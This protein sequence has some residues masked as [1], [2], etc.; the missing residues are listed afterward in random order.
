MPRLTYSLTTI[1]LVA[2]DQVELTIGCRLTASSTAFATSSSG[3]TR[4]SRQL[5]AALEPVQRLHRPG[6]VDREEL[7]DVR[8]GERRR[9]HV[10]GGQL[11]HA[12]DRDPLL[13]GRRRRP[14]R[15][16]WPRS[17]LT[18]GAR[19]RC[20]SS[21]VIEP[22]GRCRRPSPGRRRGPGPACAPAAWPAPGP[23]GGRWRTAWHRDCRRCGAGATAAG[24]ALDA[25]VAAGAAAAGGVGVAY[26]AGAALGRVW[27]S[28][29]NRPA[30]PCG[31]PAPDHR[32]CRARSAPS[33]GAT[34]T[35][36][37]DVGG[38]HRTGGRDRC[39]SR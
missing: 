10:L 28:G 20:T 8:R 32:S 14:R 21:R 12:L 9:D 23:S 25:A 13:A 29:R 26:R 38:R 27:S 30:R 39:R 15:R 17:R 4:T 7:G 1:S 33:S 34:S 22:A 16:R 35:A 6:H 11:A 5:A 37:S 24:P 3:E 18:G 2:P 19:G 31:R 36:A